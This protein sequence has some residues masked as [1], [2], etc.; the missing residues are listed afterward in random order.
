M[1]KTELG[2]LTVPIGVAAALVAVPLAAGHAVAAST[3]DTIGPWDIEATFKGEKFDRCSISRKLDDDV[4]ATFT[5]T[6]DDL[7]LELA[8]PNWKLER[9]KLYPVKMNLGPVSFDEQ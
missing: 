6:G 3:T 5:R 7:T 4:V 2:S 1:R 8:S 9:G